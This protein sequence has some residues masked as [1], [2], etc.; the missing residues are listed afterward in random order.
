MSVSHKLRDFW[1]VFF[2]VVLRLK[3]FIESN[4]VPAAVI[5]FGEIHRAL[6]QI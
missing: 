6:F 2:E 3:L 5:L 4:R 1:L